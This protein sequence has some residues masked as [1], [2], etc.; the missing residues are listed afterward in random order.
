MAGEE[1]GRGEEWQPRFTDWDGDGSGGGAGALLPFA[2]RVLST[3]FGVGLGCGVGIGVG[4]PLSLAGVPLLGGALQGMTAGL[5]ALGGAG[6]ALSGAGA[7]A[8]RAVAAL[9]L[10]GLDGPGA[11]CGVGVGYG[12]FAAGLLAK[13]SAGER[14]RRALAGAAGAAQAALRASPLGPALGPHRSSGGGGG[15]SGGGGVG[16][17]TSAAG[18]AAGLGTA[19]ANGAPLAPLPDPAGMLPPPTPA[20]KKL[21]AGDDREA[22]RALLR[23][24]RQIARLR[25]QNR[26]LR[27]AVCKLDPKAAACRAK[28]W[29]DGGASS[30]SG[31]DGG[32]G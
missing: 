30:S 22:L 15:G 17:T 7:A 2:P 24:E 32:E 29:G 10:R 9:G 12:F 27:A 19:Q 8:R 5:D 4:R 18:G 31:D 3:G 25:R 6:A 21:A 14:L 26:A 20:G 16:A 11:G 23:H 13:P 28:G 1:G